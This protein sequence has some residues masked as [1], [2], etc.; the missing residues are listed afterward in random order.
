Q[1][2]INFHAAKISEAMVG[3][4][5]RILVT[6]PSKKNPNELTGKTENMRQLNFAGDA[7]LAGQFVNVVVT[8]ALT[9]SLRGRVAVNPGVS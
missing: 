2:M 7:R 1:D 6:G 9:N 4:R 5:Q 8:A 3:S